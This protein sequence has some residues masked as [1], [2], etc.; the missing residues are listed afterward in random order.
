MTPSLKV[1]AVT[2]V[3][4]Q[5]A[6]HVTKAASSELKLRKV[7]AAFALVLAEALSSHISDL[8]ILL[9]RSRGREPETKWREKRDKERERERG[10]DVSVSS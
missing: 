10:P 3:S 1:S 2:P 9:V 7:L 6:A 5:K 4:Q 8:L